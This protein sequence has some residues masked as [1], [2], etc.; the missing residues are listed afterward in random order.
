M[1]EIT[2][3]R[4]GYALNDSIKI[5]AIDDK[6]PGGA[7]HHYL[8][9]LDP[10]DGETKPL[11]GANIRFQ[12]GPRD[13]PGSKPGV[14]SAAIMAVLID[15]LQ[16]FLG[17]FPSRETAITITKLQEALFWERHRADLRAA[18]G[19]LGKAAK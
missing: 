6:G 19:V 8:L 7:H 17:E 9:I 14:T 16:E 1:K 4:D 3:H 12:C 10:P 2:S 18:R 15:H 13:E 5:R 11:L